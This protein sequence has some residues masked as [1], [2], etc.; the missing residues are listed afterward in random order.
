TST[1]DGSAERRTPSRGFPS[2]AGSRTSNAPPAP[3]V[4]RGG[5]SRPH[6][7]FTSTPERGNASGPKTRPWI[8]CITL[9]RDGSSSFVGVEIPGARVGALSGADGASGEGG[10][11]LDS[12]GA[13]SIPARVAVGTGDSLE[14]ERIHAIAPAV[15]AIAA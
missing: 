15:T 6:S 10:A 2:V 5:G 1:S 8:L 11:G 4:A 12:S 3:L 13:L 9:V 7:N 14:S